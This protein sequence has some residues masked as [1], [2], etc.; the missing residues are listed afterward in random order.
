[1]SKCIR[2]GKTRI[3]KSTVTKKIDKNTVTFKITVCPDP[4]CQKLVDKE[5]A[6]EERKRE[7]I[8][9]KQEKRAEELALRKKKEKEAKLKALKKKG[10]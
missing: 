4:E 2:C 10:K 1:M 3:V 8:R 5:L 6:A 9:K 7:A